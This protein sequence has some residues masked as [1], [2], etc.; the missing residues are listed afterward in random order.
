MIGVIAR[1]EVCAHP[2]EYASYARQQPILHSRDFMSFGL[3]VIVLLLAQ[4]VINQC[5]QGRCF[6][7]CHGAH[8]QHRRRKDVSRIANRAQGAPSPLGIRGIK[9]TLEVVDVLALQHRRIVISRY[10]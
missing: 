3:Q 10:A 7:Q 8:V 6:A 2:S 1:I 4:R 5:T 9:E